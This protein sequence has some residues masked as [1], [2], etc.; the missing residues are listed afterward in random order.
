MWGH[1]T[2]REWNSGRP[3]Q[4]IKPVSRPCPTVVSMVRRVRTSPWQG[5]RPD[6]GRGLTRPGFDRARPVPPNMGARIML[7]SFMTAGD[8]SV[9]PNRAVHLPAPP[10]RRY[11]PA[12]WGSRRS[13]ATCLNA[14]GH[15]TRRGATRGPRP[16]Y[17]L[18]ARADY[19]GRMGTSTASRQGLAAARTD[20]SSCSRAASHHQCQLIFA[21][22]GRGSCP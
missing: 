10:G 16:V 13:I 20:P 7:A 18:L 4:Q 21:E 17:A 5:R 19:A 3:H 1:G 9:F 14:N 11:A 22:P 2:A 12:R 15:R 6:Q 8:L